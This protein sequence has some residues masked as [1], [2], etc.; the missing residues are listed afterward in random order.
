MHLPRPGASAGSVLY[1]Y[2]LVGT[3]RRPCFCLLPLLSLNT[4]SMRLVPLFVA[5]T[6]ANV[7]TG[8]LTLSRSAIFTHA[9]LPQDWFSSDEAATAEGVDFC[10]VRYVC[11]QLCMYHVSLCCVVR[12]RICFCDVCMFDLSL[13]LAVVLYLSL[14]CARV[15]ADKRMVPF[16]VQQQACRRRTQPMDRFRGRGDI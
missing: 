11:R 10:K 13:F 12:C 9:P 15:G 7:I 6:Q 14:A 1:V 16:R 5:N 3:A 8:Q 2:C 4:F